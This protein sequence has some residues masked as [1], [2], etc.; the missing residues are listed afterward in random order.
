MMPTQLFDWAK[1]NIKGIT[2]FYLSSEEVQACRKKLPSRFESTKTVAGTR[3]HHR[4]V[5]VDNLRTVNMYRL[6]GDPFYTAVL[7]SAVASVEQLLKGTT[8][9]ITPAVG[10][11]VAAIY[12]NEWYV[13][14]V[15]ERS[16]E[17]GDVT[18]NFM[19]R[20]INTNIIAWPS[21]K[22]ECAVPLQ[23]VLCLISTPAVSGSTGRQYKLSQDNV[24]LIM[25]KYEA[26]AQ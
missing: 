21:H 5:P 1:R 12:D 11:Y 16:E 9:M 14:M 7:V 26:R 13:G 19:S 4:F 25:Q 17:H 10:Q 15:T 23:N 3:S 20:N 8:E 22:D 2:F 24:T 6:S 18:I